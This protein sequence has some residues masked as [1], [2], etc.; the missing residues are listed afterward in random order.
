MEVIEH[1]SN[2]IE[3]LRKSLD[4]QTFSP[5][6]IHGPRL[7][8]PE[9][10]NVIKLSISSSQLGICLMDLQ[11]DFFDRFIFDGPP[12]WPSLL[13]AVTSGE[14]THCNLHT[15]RAFR[16]AS[17]EPTHPNLHTLTVDHRTQAVGTLTFIH[18][19]R[20]GP[21]GKPNP[22]IPRHSH[23]IIPNR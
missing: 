16:D 19:S 4:F 21:K 1:P 20:W 13:A 8:P 6:C 11:P 22:P 12:V 2:F 10:E 5:L 7:C 23:G 3:N 17:G 15:L 9:P 18:C 14:R